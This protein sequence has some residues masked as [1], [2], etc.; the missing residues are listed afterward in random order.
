MM[1]LT[2]RAVGAAVAAVAMLATGAAFAADATEANIPRRVSIIPFQSETVTPAQF[3]RGEEGTPATIAGELRVP[4]PFDST[5]KLATVVLLHGGGGFV[6]GHEL[7][8]RELLEEGFAVFLVDSQSGRGGQVGS[9]LNVIVDLYAA[10]GAIANHPRV[11]AS[12]IIAFGFSLGARAVL[13]SAVTRFDERWNRSGVEV[14]GRVAF[15]PGCE[16]TYVDDSTVSAAPIRLFGGTADLSVDVAKCLAYAERIR[17]AGA[18]VEVAVYP[19]VGHGFEDPVSPPVVQLRASRTTR[20]CT[21]VEGPPGV[22][23]NVATGQPPADTDACLGTG[24][25]LVYD[26]AAHQASLAAVREFLGTFNP[27]Q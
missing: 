21:F 13:Y 9:P 2:G 7:W 22:V 14:A 20:E 25:Q 1:K 11:D 4:M 16:T 5:E 6:P 18:D 27:T 23:I 24:G 8:A 15:F 26:A 12:R 19:G 3:L 17:A 10:L